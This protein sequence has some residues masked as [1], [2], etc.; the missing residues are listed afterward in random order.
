[1]EVGKIKSEAGKEIYA[2]ERESQIYQKLESEAGGPL[3]KD[4][5]KAAEDRVNQIIEREKDAVPRK[6]EVMV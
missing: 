1:M 6:K 3:P 5:L 4:A 2:P